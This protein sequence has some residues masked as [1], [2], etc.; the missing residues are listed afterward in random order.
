MWQSRRSQTEHNWACSSSSL[1]L[2][3]QCCISA[4]KEKLKGNR[5]S[6]WGAILGRPIGR[7]YS[8]NHMNQQCSHT[9]Q[10]IVLWLSWISLS[11]SLF[12][13]NVT[14][15]KNF[16]LARWSPRFCPCASMCA[17]GIGEIFRTARIKQKN[18]ES[19]TLLCNFSFPPP[20]PTPSGWFISFHHFLVIL[21]VQFILGYTWNIGI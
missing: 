17:L 16:E 9:V 8:R 12:P 14:A 10:L 13:S 20:H 1:L 21:F 19:L 6:F 5:R 3:Q 2:Q 15:L 4:K 11:L 7:T 18:A